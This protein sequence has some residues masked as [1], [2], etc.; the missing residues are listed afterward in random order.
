MQRRDLTSAQIRGIWPGRYN[1]RAFDTESRSLLIALSRDDL[2]DQERASGLYFVPLEGD[3]PRQAAEGEFSDLM[4]DE[5]AELFIAI[6]EWDVEKR[7]AVAVDGS[8]HVWDLPMPEGAYGLPLVSPDGERLAWTGEGL[9]MT[10]LTAGLAEP[11][12][13][14][15][16]ARI[17]EAAWS[18]TGE[19]LLFFSSEGFFIASEPGFAPIALPGLPG[20]NLVWVE[21]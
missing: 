3:Q 10:R 20:S 19:G 11:P 1:A 4:W 2:C 9:W 14:V 21:P 16:E 5:A 13:Q 17:D 6:A 18:P 15:Q 7:S 12:L 8:G